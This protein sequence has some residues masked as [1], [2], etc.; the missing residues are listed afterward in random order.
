M[1]ENSNYIKSML[2]TYL[3]SV[4]TCTCEL[5]MLRGK[6]FTVDGLIFVGYQLSWRAPSTNSSANEIVIFCTS[7]EGKYNDHEF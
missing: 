6:H 4:S 3:N 7:Y 2:F 1:Y 5:I